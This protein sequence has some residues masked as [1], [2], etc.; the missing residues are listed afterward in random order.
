MWIEKRKRSRGANSIK[1]K[2]DIMVEDGSQES[3]LSELEP[4]GT[5]LEL[6][7]GGLAGVE[8]EVIK[9]KW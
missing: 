6:V 5:K 8:F 1:A 3:N 7:G 4:K 9:I 2:E